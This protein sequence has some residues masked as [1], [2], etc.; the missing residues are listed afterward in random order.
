MNKAAAAAATSAA[1]FSGCWVLLRLVI[2]KRS[3]C[4]IKMQERE[5]ISLAHGL[6]LDLFT[7]VLLIIMPF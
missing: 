6:G 1:W 3:R 4:R 7:L 2:G 5:L